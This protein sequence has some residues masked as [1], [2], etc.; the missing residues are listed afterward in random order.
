MIEG[1]VRREQ[2]NVRQLIET[3]VLILWRNARHY[4]DSIKYTFPLH[5]NR[6]KSRIHDMRT[7]ENLLIGDKEPSA[8][9][10]FALPDLH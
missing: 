10:N 4:A 9:E 1:L 8:P 7:G 2:G 3:T 6:S 5:S